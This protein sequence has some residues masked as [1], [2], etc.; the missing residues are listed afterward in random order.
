[1]ILRE[2][3]RNLESSLRVR[4]GLPAAVG[5]REIVLAAGERALLSPR[6]LRALEPLL[7]Q[8]SA[9]EIAVMSARRLS[10]SDRKLAA[11][12]DGVLE[13]LTEMVE[14]EN[15]KRDSRSQHG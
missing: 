2:L 5:P 14:L 11:L 10:I 13:I 6:S 15:P 3:K 4:L 9:G 8:L 1:M 12:H 7:T